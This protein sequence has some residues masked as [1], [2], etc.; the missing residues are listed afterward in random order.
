MVTD[1]YQDFVLIGSKKNLTLTCDIPEDGE[2]FVYVDEGKVRQIISNLVDNAIKYTPEGS[3]H[4]MLRK[5]PTH[6]V[7]GTIVLEIKDTGIGLSLDDIT[8]L[9]GKFTRGSEGSR[10][11]TTG[12]GLGLYIAKK[13]M[14]EHK[15][16]IWVESP[17]KGMGSSFFIELP[18]IGD[19]LSIPE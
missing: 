12:S 3:V 5:E 13:M 14:A 9:F 2:W 10:I 18:E 17:G 11:D 4:I 7:H 16:D 15:G 1:V 8:H 6:D 19:A